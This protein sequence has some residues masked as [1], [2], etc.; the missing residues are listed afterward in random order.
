M[1]DNLFDPAVHSSMEVE[2]ASYEHTIESIKRRLYEG[3]R[4]QDILSLAREFNVR[5]PDQLNG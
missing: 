3:E 2:L 1:Q 4:T 5:V